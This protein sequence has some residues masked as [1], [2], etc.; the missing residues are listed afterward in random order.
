MAR[1]KHPEQTIEQILAVSERL[2]IERGY[3]KTTIQ[4]IIDELR[5][6]KGAIYHHFKSKEEILE[7]IIAAKGERER[8]LMLRLAENTRGE[9]AKDKIRKL[10]A[11]HFT[12]STAIYDGSM[13]DMLS[14][15]M[16]DPRF[17]AAGLKSCV[18]KDAPEIAV[19]LSAG[20][21]DGSIQ[22]EYPLEYAEIF[23]LLVSI[24]TKPVFFNRNKEQTKRR[25]NALQSLMKGVGVDILSD[26]AIERLTAF[27]DE[28]GFYNV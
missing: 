25:L 21:E 2:F 14:Y 3:D 26:E 10:L 19:L 23:L 24:W 22:T 15:Q 17:I 1:N 8:N 28:V 6:S 16:K 7:A 12:G 18:M 4:N 9:N 20:I 27:Y 11:L 5:L 13:S